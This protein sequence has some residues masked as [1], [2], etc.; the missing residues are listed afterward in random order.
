M[1]D[2]GAWRNYPEVVEGLLSPA[3]KTIAFTIALDF[4][5]DIRVE[6]LGGSE[7]IDHN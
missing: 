4:E 5:L 2:S 7:S 6:R 3:E 1:T